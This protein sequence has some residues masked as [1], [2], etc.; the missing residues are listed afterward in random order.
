M[1][2]LIDTYIFLWWCTDSSKLSNKAREL[3][4]H[5][6]TEV[7]LSLGS[8]WE[9]AIKTS[10]KKLTITQGN[11]ATFL[12]THLEKN[13]IKLLPISFSHI[14]Q[15]SALPFIHNDPFDRLLVAQCLVEDIPLLTEDK[16]IPK[17]S[18]KLA[19]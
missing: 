7:Y 17:Y 5:K 13:N 4:S 9:M 15:V 18:I 10:L 3:I 11:F 12:P 19:L 8:A 1:K 6:N 2:L 16:I 14:I